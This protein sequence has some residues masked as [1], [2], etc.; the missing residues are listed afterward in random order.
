MYFVIINFFFPP[1]GLQFQYAKY[2][3]FR[4]SLADYVDV[5]PIF[6]LTSKRKYPFVACCKKIQIV[7][8]Q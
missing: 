4:N 3:N 5:I 6:C 2:R 8:P 7:G 1:H